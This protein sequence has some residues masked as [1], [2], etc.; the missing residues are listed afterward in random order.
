MTALAI[1]IGLSLLSFV[2]FLLCLAMGEHEQEQE[3]RF[4]IDVGEVVPK[5][6]P[7]ITI[8]E[9]QDVSSY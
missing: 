4:T 5:S 1:A 2:W 8:V 3:E 7:K 6:S 9:S